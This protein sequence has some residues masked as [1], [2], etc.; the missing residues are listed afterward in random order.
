MDLLSSN[1]SQRS[2]EIAAWIYSKLK[3]NTL[4]FSPSTAHLQQLLGYIE[5]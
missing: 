1:P 2:R 5:P 3:L 4:C